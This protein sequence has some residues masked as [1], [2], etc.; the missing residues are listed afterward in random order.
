MAIYSV[1]GK[2]GTG[3]S[4]FTVWQAQTA[5]YEGRKVAGNVDLFLD[6]LTPNLTQCSYTR[7]P[8]RP[9]AKDLHAIGHGNPDSYD[10]ERNGV[11]ILDELGSWMNAR[12]YQER[13]R[14]DVID[15][16]IHARKLGWDVYFIVQNSQMID[17]QIRESLIEY[18]CRCIR[19][20]KVKIPFFGSFLGFIHK[21]WAYLPRMHIVTARV[22]FTGSQIVAQRW[23]F[24]GDDLH[25]AYDTRQ[26]FKDDPGAA[27]YTVFHPHRFTGL[28]ARRTFS[29]VF[30]DLFKEKPRHRITKPCQP[31]IQ[32]LKD[33]TILS[34][35]TKLRLAATYSRSVTRP[36][37]QV[38]GL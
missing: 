7:I 14:Q 4:K 28:P 33:S 20:D 27:A 32:A 29:Q 2:L 1:E 21:R 26:I 37:S 18:Q 15:W 36:A 11:L 23:H 3:K 19:L 10:E 25:K 5:L 12:T 6:H 17:K 30:A 16:L 13:G 35:E 9:T 24:R 34:N 8:D 31:F 22:G 38:V